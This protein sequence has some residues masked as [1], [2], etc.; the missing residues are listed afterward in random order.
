MP[1][2]TLEDKVCKQLHEF[3]EPVELCDSTGKVLGKFMPRFDPSE[4]I[5][6]GEELSDEELDQLEKSNP[7][8]Y[9]TAEV[10][11]HLRSLGNA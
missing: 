4:W 6:E 11:A 1:K 7:K 3:L 9:S 10:L 8:R 2:I 5:I